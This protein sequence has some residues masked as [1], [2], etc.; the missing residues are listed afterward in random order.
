MMKFLVPGI[1]ALITLLCIISPALADNGPVSLSFSSAKEEGGYITADLAFTPLIADGKNDG[2]LS[3]WFSPTGDCGEARPLGW[4]YIPLAQEAKQV[5]MKAAV[6][7]SVIAGAYTIT[8]I[9]GPGSL[10]PVA[11]DKGPAA[12][13][14]VTISTP[15]QGTHDMAGTLTGETGNTTGPNYRID[16]LTGVDTAIRVAP[17]AMIEPS[18]TIT[19]TGSADESGVP[20]EVHAYLGSEE[21]T[22]VK[23][24]INPMKG[25]VSSTSS[26]SYMI[27]DTIPLHSYPFYL[28]VDPRGE[29]G[30]PDAAT[31]LK[32]T[33]GQ[34]SVRVEVPGVGCGC[35]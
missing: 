18:V 2:Y 26:L 35:K 33:G 14:T 1:L 28:I 23:G 13:T 20:V 16:S 27:P 12:A 4:Q 8:A 32:R 10:I 5:S 25:G 6:P 21:L 7:Y 34:M 3:F 9:Y 29:H 22:P 11:C 19:N 31:N 15:G 24:V 17:G 30:A